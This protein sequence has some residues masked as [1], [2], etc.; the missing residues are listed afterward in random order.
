MVLD[1]YIRAGSKHVTGLFEL[2]REKAVLAIS[3]S[4]TT[5]LLVK[6]RNLC[7]NIA[8]ARPIA[9]RKFRGIF[10]RNVL[11]RTQEATV[12]PLHPIALQVWS[13]PAAAHDDSA[14]A[15]Y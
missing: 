3:D 14:F 10:A 5:Q 13:E 1:A 7:E 12:P 11:G 8:Q 6:L 9:A 2:P 15:P 4:A